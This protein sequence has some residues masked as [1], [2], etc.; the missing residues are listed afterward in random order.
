MNESLVRKFCESPHR[1]LI[2]VIVTTLFGLLVLIPLVDDYFNK[3][4]SHNALTDELDHA[5]L[6]AEGLPAVEQQTA[7]VLEKLAEI[8]ARTV[9]DE[10][11]GRYRSN[12]VDL[13]RDAGC[14]VRRFDVSA[15]TLRPWTEDDNPLEKTA[16]QSAKTQQTPFAL[17]QRTVVLLVDGSMQ[18]I[19]KL[20]GQLNK[21]DSLS[22][23]DYLELKSNSP[24]GEQVTLEIRVNLF[25]LNRQR[26]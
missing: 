3:E 18:S 12:V 25:A 6:T 11:V 14:Q 19:Q 10:T 1:K 9:T 16:S 7:E 13:V 20:L 24:S 17:E 4:E 26:A 8:E 2:V 21:D 23:L 5:R 15:P 22:Y